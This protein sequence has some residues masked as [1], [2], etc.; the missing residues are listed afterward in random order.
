MPSGIAKL[1][2]SA[3]YVIFSIMVAATV[4]CA[5]LVPKV[6]VITDMAE[7]LPADSPMRAGLAIME[8]EFPDSKELSTTRVMFAGLA[9][10]DEK[11]ILQT[12]EKIP[13]VDA[14]AYE[15]DSPIYH[16]GDK[17]LYIVQSTAAYGS[18]QDQAIQST[19][20]EKLAA[21]SPVIR[22]DNPSPSSELPLWIVMV[23]VGL[24]ALILFIMCA[25]WLEPVL[26]L[27]AI[28]MAVVL[29]LGTNLIRGSI[30][31]I[32][33]T[34]GAILQL[35]LS[36]DYS[37]ILMN[38]YR[39]EK[40]GAATPAEAMTRAIRGAFSSI[41]SS[42]MTTVVG[43]LMLCFMSLGIGLDLGIALAKG[44]FLSMV[45]VFTVLPTLILWFDKAIAATAK[46]YW[47]PNLAGLA[48]VEHRL[49]W[50]ILLAFIALFAGT[51]V[52]AA[53]TPV[54]YTLS[55]DDPIADVFPKENPVVL[56]YDNTDEAAAGALAERIGSESFVRSV[57]SQSS[58][59][60]KQRSLADM[61]SALA[62]MGDGSLSL[63]DD[64]LA[65]VYYL[66]HD[67]RA[68]QD[69]TLAEFVDFV[70][71]DETIANRL[72]P[73]MSARLDQI[74][75]YLDREKLVVPLGAAGLASVL[76]MS[77]EEARGILLYHAMTD[78][79]IGSDAMTLPEFVS[80]VQNDLANDPEYS[81]LLAG[82]AI[83]QVR[84]M[85]RF[86]DAAAMTTPIGSGEMAAL[87][88]L[89]PTE[90]ALLYAQRMAA[91][92]A[93]SNVSKPLPEMVA[94]VRS[95]VAS[96]PE[97]SASMSDEQK[98]GLEKLA[99][100]AD[101][102][103]VTTQMNA[104]G[105]SAIFGI[106][107]E[108]VTALLVARAQASGRMSGFDP[109]TLTA[110]PAEFVAF[111]NAALADPASP[112]A[113]GF[114]DEQKTQLA[115]LA[116]IIGASASGAPVSVSDFAAMTGIDPSVV[117]L[118]LAV[119]D[120]PT[121][122]AGWT[123]T[124]QEIVAALDEDP[125]TAA[126]GRGD[127]IARL[128]TI[129]D[130]SISGTA[131]SPSKLAGLTGMSDAQARQLALLRTSK[132]GDSSSW[133]M[134]A[135]DALAFVVDT[136]LTGQQTSSRFTASQAEQ[137]RS[138]RAIVGSVVDQTRYTPEKL[139]SF[140]GRIGQAVEVPQIQLAYLAHAAKDW[141]SS[142]ATLSIAQLVKTLSKDVVDDARFAP[143]VD[144]K[145]RA[146]IA[147]ADDQIADAVLELVGPHHSRMVITTTLPAESADTEAFV[148]DL[149]K[150]CAADFSKGCRLV[151]DSV[152]IHE[153]SRSF[154][155]E[156][157]LISWLT[158]ASIFAVVA[159]TF[160]SL[161]VPLLLVL[162][163]Q[164]GVFITITTI[165]LQ[166]YSNY[167][168]AQLM[169]Q[170]ILMGATIDY[171]I[172][173]T[174][175]YREVRRSLPPPEALAR[176]YDRS[177]HTIATSGSIMIVVTGILGYL[178]ENPTVGQIC[179]T[180]SIGALA[181]TILI[182]FVLPGLLTALDRFVAGRG[183]LGNVKHAAADSAE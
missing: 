132:Y 129:I 59:I 134:T 41:V 120:I 2:V 63:D 96:V 109:S 137:L 65:L 79:T 146:A 70:R 36:M 155:T 125:R 35:V 121:A 117:A 13:N 73:T 128:R 133:S 127:D 104:A 112:L 47:H 80:F 147:D 9:D 166:G 110:S 130:D 60:G 83:D 101:Q 55:K 144:A 78:P 24:L 26:F 116:A 163:V 122:G 179:R 17:T 14:V 71:S 105:L 102:Q 180:I 76:G 62:E 48:R 52:T 67:G 152:L 44:V 126:S 40:P 175:Q 131:Y 75:P 100:L 85:A 4:V 10:S 145:S 66:A 124:P 183:R 46:P 74:V 92:G 141:D 72:D 154:S 28:G 167:Y 68:T 103:T 3:R 149:E 54:A 88:G 64:A 6:G 89:D 156:M 107:A 113:A 178:F 5:F 8:D 93:Y 150:T 69:M 114:T 176:A 50:P 82:H 168:L 21:D 45:A 142:T 115:G 43:L 91:S 49:R 87:L 139:A 27:V 153:M 174:T 123:Y 173:L 1:L 160:F 111:L 11:R 86:T 12:L 81:S 108:Q 170:C 165:G 172:L 39:Q 15:A 23:A 31:D 90:T 42:S 38:R 98:A 97:A 136:M 169:V 143:F 177:I 138:L 53:G 135:Q 171:G 20:E 182:V 30:A 140:L 22:S 164:C 158:A 32:T 94:A 34:I 77:E 18:A 106:P 58:T 33:F 57:A 37:I 16:E 95:L 157:S 148:S 56:V 181:A 7:F 118:A 161:S 84:Q 25:S 19:I 61:K 51:A 159:L 162:L 151:G 99:V 29:N 119:A